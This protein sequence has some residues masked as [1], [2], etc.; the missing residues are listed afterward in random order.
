M[1]PLR[2]TPWG[3]SERKQESVLVTYVGLG[4]RCKGE[5]WESKCKCPPP[6]PI[7]KNRAFLGV[8]K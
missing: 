3:G 8:E 5:Y 6:T 2:V 1:R 4:H 7:G